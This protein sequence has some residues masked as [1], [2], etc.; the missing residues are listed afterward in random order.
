MAHPPITN[1][2]TNRLKFHKQGLRLRDRIVTK[3]ETANLWV[4]YH[5]GA[6]PALTDG[7]TEPYT[8]L[9][10][11]FEPFNPVKSRNG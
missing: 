9:S 10:R 4:E 8:N 1:I 11:I 6:V 2:G 7:P 3:V 5:G